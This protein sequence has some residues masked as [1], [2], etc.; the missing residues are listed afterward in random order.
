MVAVLKLLIRFFIPLT[1]LGDSSLGDLYF[2]ISSDLFL[3]IPSGNDVLKIL[4]CCNHRKTVPA[5]L[6]YFFNVFNVLQVYGDMLKKLS[7][8]DFSNRLRVDKY[9]IRLKIVK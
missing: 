7:L 3:L 1:L 2:V 8:L 4:Y 5:L 9:T 6:T